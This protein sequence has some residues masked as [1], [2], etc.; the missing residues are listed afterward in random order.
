MELKQ[1]IAL[2]LVASIAAVTC[3]GADYS[4][5]AARP[6]FDDTYVYVGTG[7]REDGTK[8]IRATELEIG[9]PIF[10]DTIAAVNKS[11]LQ[12]SIDST[13]VDS[14]LGS[15][16]FSLTQIFRETC[17]A[18]TK[19][20]VDF[21]SIEAGIV[22]SHG[23]QQDPVRDVDNGYVSLRAQTGPSLYR[24]EFTAAAARVDALAHE[25]TTRATV[26]AGIRSRLKQFQVGLDVI[27]SNRRH[28]TQETSL[29]LKGKYQASRPLAIYAGYEKG[30]SDAFKDHYWQ[31][32]IE[33]F[34]GR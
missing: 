18:Q 6:P 10:T 8:E 20:C 1:R 19:L 11:Y 4:M 7:Q 16:T 9:V 21:W 32:G 15:T 13:K 31:A 25:G 24:F 28:T 14:G 12:T 26:T 34:Y 33:W 2:G 29:N 27:V 22:D 23:P 17:E 3:E 5:R 30:I